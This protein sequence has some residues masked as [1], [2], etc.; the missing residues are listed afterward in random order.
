LVALRRTCEASKS[1]SKTVFAL[2]LLG[3]AQQI[4][5]PSKQFRPYGRRTIQPVA[6]TAQSSTEEQFVGCEKRL[7]ICWTTS[8]NCDPESGIHECA[9]K[10]EP[11]AKGFTQQREGGTIVVANA[12][13]TGA[14]QHSREAARD[15][16]RHRGLKTEF[17]I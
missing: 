3:G 7:S 13:Q 12:L 17:R 4:R 9:V 8:G 2:P 14:V 15:V 10:Q 16:L 1:L 5:L 6:F 11:T